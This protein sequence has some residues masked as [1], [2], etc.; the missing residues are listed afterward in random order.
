MTEEIGLRP[1][2]PLEPSRD[3]SKKLTLAGLVLLAVLAVWMLVSQFGSALFA[4]Q[5]TSVAEMPQ[6]EFTEAT[7]I[8][9]TL[10]AI[11]AAGGM[12]DIRYQVIDPDKAV[13]VHDEDKPP[14]II[15]ADTG[16]RLFFTR[17]SGHDF[18]LHTAVTY[19]YHIINSGGLIKRGETITVQIGDTQLE[20]VPVQ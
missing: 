17:H 10:V 1:T 11:T 18:D 19:S 20:N 6:T 2:Q 5:I 4:P 14:L 3:A 15:D 9:L 12:I 7:G 13:V 8:R 16:A